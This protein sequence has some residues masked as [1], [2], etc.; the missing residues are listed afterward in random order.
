VFV[1]GISAC[2]LLVLPKAGVDAA[3]NG[4][5]VRLKIVRQ[6]SGKDCT[7]GQISIEGKLAG[8]TLERPW[9]GNIPLISSIPAGQYHGH[10]RTDTSDRWRIQLTDVPGRTGIQLHVGNFLADGVGCILIG[11]NLT[12]N[13]CTLIDGKKGF[14]SFKLAF[15]AA[16]VQK[17]LPA[18]KTPVEL[19]IGD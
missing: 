7:S 8:Y 19:T 18:D 3:Q 14:D 15:A 10:V 12:V 11:A 13:L 1:L 9:E 16:A 5:A 2:L 4:N 6:H 17:G